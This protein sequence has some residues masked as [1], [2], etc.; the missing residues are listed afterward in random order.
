MGQY[1]RSVAGVD[2]TDGSWV[3]APSRTRPVVAERRVSVAGECN[4][5]G[6]SDRESPPGAREPEAYGRYRDR[7][8]D[9][10]EKEPRGWLLRSQAGVPVESDEVWDWHDGHVCDYAPFEPCP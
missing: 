7:D 6:V 1:P 8:G 10:W 9:E 3:E 4:R 2:V 5:T